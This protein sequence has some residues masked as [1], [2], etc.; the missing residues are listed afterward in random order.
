MRWPRDLLGVATPDVARGVRAAFVT[1]APFYLAAALARPE[2]AW[3]ALGG[4]LGTLADPGGPRAT[5]A[6]ALAIF[7]V[8]GTPLVAAFESV[9]WAP[10]MATA[11]L[12]LIAFAMSMLRSV[13]GSAA[14]LGNFL[15]MVAAIGGARVRTSPVSDALG[16]ALGAAMAVFMSTIVWP[17]WTHLPVRRAV[18]NVYA[19]L[20]SYVAEAARMH[21]AEQK[22]ASAWTDLV[23][24]H[25]RQIRDALESARVAALAGRARR[26]GES[27]YGGT[28]RA[29]L[30]AAE[31]QFPIVAS[32][33]IELESRALAPS[34]DPRR[35]DALAA[36][37]RAVATTLAS[38]E[39][40]R[41][42]PPAPTLSPTL[43]PTPATVADHL[44]DR[45]DR[46][47]TLVRDLLHALASDRG[48]PA[49][50]PRDT[51]SLP[52]AP[53]PGPVSA[54]RDVTTVPIALRAMRDALSWRSP[55]LQ[56]ALRT[57]LAAGA[58]SLVGEL[59]SRSRVY[60]VT[61]TT[62]AILQPYP[63]ATM[64]RAGER[65][66]GTIFGCIAALVI[67]TSVH[68]RLA[69]A[70]MLVPLSVAA[71]A[72][73]PRSYRLF[74]FFLTPLFVIVTDP[75]HDWHTAALRAGDAVLG[76]L[77][78]LLAG[79]LIAP[80][81]ERRRAPEA[82]GDM[83]AFLGD[84]A[85]AVFATLRDPKGSLD[86]SHVA[87]KRR[88]TGLALGAAETSLERWLAEPLTDR[89]NAADAMLLVTYARRL[90]SALTSLDV[91][92]PIARTA[93]P[94][95]TADA[96]AVAAYVAATLEAARAHLAT[97]AAEPAIPAP[98]W[99]HPPAEPSI[100]RALERVV[101]WAALI[102]GVVQRDA[103]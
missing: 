26:Q 93:G 6:R 27:R 57:A 1:L 94:A 21:S 68:S 81:S 15:T 48:P 91:L 28:V 82:L 51:A 99:L 58:A 43:N 40:R 95:G 25:H 23:R 22:A 17:V 47:C 100:E 96:A 42:M 78:A 5:R 76:G 84:Y 79:V 34:V 12:M 39:V 60:W 33:V 102:A 53:Q 90:A 69:L 64:K 37:Y 55:Y 30:G 29:L 83:L 11:G 4:W 62:L 65:V 10:T 16:F 2:L 72:T 88:A 19:A 35:L 7:V 14:T 74:T 87:S 46:A 73:R 20:A 38:P 50:E 32:L 59:L 66:V 80:A 75:T 67:T 86:D 8:A 89:G 70:L 3:T 9:A 77:V 36:G 45:L 41:H 63:G 18:A 49:T 56:H 71:V 54:A 98:P 13:S 101:R 92:R 61:L 85:A 24:T 31:L 44:F 97:G 52:G 103:T